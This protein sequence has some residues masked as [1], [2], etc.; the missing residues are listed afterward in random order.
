M[1]QNDTK[2]H[3]LVLHLDEL[4]TFMDRDTL[5]KWKKSAFELI[6]STYSDYS[7]REQMRD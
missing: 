6:E 4:T 2:Y 1:H 7:A 3:R 5:N